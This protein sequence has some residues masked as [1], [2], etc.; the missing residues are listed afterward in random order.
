MITNKTI[1][2]KVE[3]YGGIR[4]LNIYQDKDDVQK[5]IFWLAVGNP[6]DEYTI[7]LNF[8]E[9]DKI[10]AEVNNLKENKIIK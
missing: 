7:S 5:G 2:Q 9:F 1:I 10:I 8:E 6:Q 3:P 4:E